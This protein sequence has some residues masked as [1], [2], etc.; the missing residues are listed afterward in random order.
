MG[1]VDYI[2]AKLGEVEHG[3]VLETEVILVRPDESVT[4]DRLARPLTRETLEAGGGEAANDH[5]DYRDFP[6]GRRHHEEGPPVCACMHVH[7]C[8]CTRV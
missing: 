8:V 6:L 3:V 5:V 4:E 7:V 2:A 1:I